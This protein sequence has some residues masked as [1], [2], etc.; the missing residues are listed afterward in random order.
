MPKAAKSETTQNFID[1]QTASIY[2]IAAQWANKS[3]AEVIC[4]NLINRL[5]N[6]QFNFRVPDE[7]SHEP[8]AEKI[9]IGQSFVISNFLFTSNIESFIRT[10]CS[11]YINSKQKYEPFDFDSLF[12]ELSKM[13]QDLTKLD[14]M[15][16]QVWIN[17]NTNIQKII[18][19]FIENKTADTAK[20]PENLFSMFTS[21]YA[22][23]KSKSDKVANAEI[24]NMQIALAKSL[25]ISK[26]L[27]LH[28]LRL[29][30]QKKSEYSSKPLDG[31]F[32]LPEYLGFWGDEQEGFPK[33]WS[34][35]VDDEH[36]LI[37]CDA[38]KYYT[39]SHDWAKFE[40]LMKLYEKLT[41]QPHKSD[42]RQKA[43]DEIEKIQ[44]QLRKK[45]LTLFHPSSCKLKAK[46][47]A[48]KTTAEDI[49]YIQLKDMVESGRMHTT[50]SVGWVGEVKFQPIRIFKPEYKE[51]DAASF[52]PNKYKLGTAETNTLFKL[53]A[54]MARIGY[55]YEE[56]K[57][58]NL[59]TADIVGDTGVDHKTVKKWVEIA[60]ANT[61]V[62]K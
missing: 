23:G 61:P 30:L 33:S 57:E 41:E 26:E 62:P 42:E 28:W 17:M 27:F 4:L 55:S 5:K 13:K 35:Q 43:G 47:Y 50:K 54:G 60:T 45:F 37:L 11:W 56:G 48:D 2:E 24:D 12:A 49:S 22:E 3:D 14:G 1:R 10:R 40:S 34:N 18:C 59:A 9:S 21:Q 36:G 25:F 32:L 19:P 16:Y 58:R 7:I 8:S 52:K 46:G 15:E 44:M 29:G 31:D 53:I 51:D 39:D 38:F 20:A 6:G